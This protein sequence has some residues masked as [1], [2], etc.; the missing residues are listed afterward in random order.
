MTDLLSNKEFLEL[1]TGPSYGLVSE[2]GLKHLFENIVPA[3]QEFDDKYLKQ[4]QGQL[5]SSVVSAL[6]EDR[7]I[8]NKTK[9]LIDFVVQGGP[10]T[11]ET[12]FRGV[13][14][15]FLALVD[16]I[17]HMLKTRNIHSSR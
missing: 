15:R 14:H 10:V 7:S 17:Y 16:A 5:G 6:S 13:V 3:C 2:T 12:L 11:S 9:E 1:E 8:Y 4:M